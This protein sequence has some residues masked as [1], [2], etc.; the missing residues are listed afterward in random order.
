MALLQNAQLSTL[1]LGYNNLEDKGVIILA[2]GISEHHALES[3]DLGFNN[4]GEQ[5]CKA[6]ASSIPTNGSLHTLYLAGNLIGEEGAMAVADVVRRGSTLHRLYMTGNRVGP[7]GVKALTEAMLEDELRRRSENEKTEAENPASEENITIADY[8][9]NSQVGM[10]ELFLGGTGLEIGGC[11]ATARLLRNTTCLRV[12]S[13]PNCDI[14]DDA[15]SQLAS[16]IKANRQMLPLETLHL[17]FNSITSRGMECLANAIWG[18]RTL[19]KLL[20]DNNE[21]GDRGTHQIATVLPFLPTLE[22]LDVGFNSIKAAGIKLLMKAVAETRSLLSLSVSGNT[23]DTSGAKAIAYALAYNRSLLSLVLVH[24]SVGSEG[25]RHISAGIV[26]NSRI[27]LRELTGFNIGPA[28]VTL[29]FPGP[30][31]HWNNEQILNFIHVMW[32]QSSEKMT[33]SEEEKTL[34]PLHFLQNGGSGGANAVINRKPPLE[35]TIVVDVAKKAF[36][37]L[38]AKGVDVFSR[39]PGHPNELAVASPIAGDNIVVESLM[40]PASI[41][42]EESP[43]ESPLEVIPTRQAKSFVAPPETPKKSLPDPSRKKRIVEWLSTNIQRLNKLAQQ[44][45][46]SAELWKLHQHFFTP[47]VNETGGSVAPSPDPSANEI[48]KNFWSVPEVSREPSKNSPVNMMGDPSEDAL[49]VPASDPSMQNSRGAMASL[50]MLKR[51][52][53]Y[54]FLGDAALTMPAAHRQTQSERS[55]S[56]SMMI[57]GGPIVHSMPPKTKRARRNRARI[58]FL[59]RVKAKLDSYLDVC[60]EKALA[61]MRQL[62][63]VEQAILGGQIIPIDP[64]ITPRTHLC[65]DFAA[66]AEIIV[67]DMM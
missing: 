33:T 43:S 54:R 27:A 46:S 24:C 4:F 51:K 31:E 11:R 50:P 9:D 55:T 23:L 53:S 32:E 22:H 47:V 38:I 10:Q 13:L 7:D 29:G 14:G 63:Y 35:A 60:H 65:G 39:R 45:F 44:P 26:S 8:V 30:L 5:G 59:P 67:A 41:N 15:V 49:M 20:L 58:S 40:A 48:G 56:V 16:S 3:L 17:S 1:K 66:D 6:L 62:Y 19:K 52:V 36:S 64:A 57:E 12:L 25:Q 18:S 37:S 21:I 61:T 28:V 34:D 2:S 42:E